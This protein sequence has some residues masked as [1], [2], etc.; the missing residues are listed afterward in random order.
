[1]EL[2]IIE[3]ISRNTRSLVLLKHGDCYEVISKD[4]TWINETHKYD[5]LKDALNKLNELT[6]VFNDN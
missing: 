1:M 5:E 3:K 6:E 4:G 2:R